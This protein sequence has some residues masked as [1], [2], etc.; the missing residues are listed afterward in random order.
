MRLLGLTLLVLA[1]I[2]PSAGAATVDERKLSLYGDLRLRLESDWDSRQADGTEREDRRRVR[3]RARLGLEYAPNE[4]VLVGA[5]LRSGS[6][7][8][9]QS[10]HITILDFDGNDTGDAEFNLDRWFLEARRSGFWG[11]AGRNSA[12]FWKQNELFWDDDATPLGLAA[13]YRAG[14]RG[15]GKLSLN[16]AYLSLPVGM[17]RFSGNLGL[18]Q[19]VYETRAGEMEYTLAGAFF[20]FDADQDDP[21]AAD[22]LQGNGSREYCIWVGSGQ[23]RI[24][25]GGRPLIL[26]EVGS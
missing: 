22:L 1:V 7:A 17:R 13:G 12:P 9:Q 24:P 3:M 21:D 16:A 15:P 10:P 5:R 20:V 19:V 6:D 14:L 26:G 11:W 4:H 8:S 25:L 2:G 23:I 18:A